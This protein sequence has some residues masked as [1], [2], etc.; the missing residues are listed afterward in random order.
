MV[1]QSRRHAV[2]IRRVNRR[3][4]TEWVLP[5]GHI[6]AGETA[7]LAAEREV[8]EETGITGSAGAAL[9]WIEYEFYAN[10]IK[11]RKIVRHF[12]LYMDG[13]ALST[14]D[15]EVSEVAWFPLER[16]EA[17]LSHG[18]ERRIVRC[19]IEVLNGTRE[20]NHVSLSV[21]NVEDLRG[22]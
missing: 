8:R 12:L 17:K 18:D 15:H 14:E 7:R 3:G 19:A 5:K 10:R 4:R 2:A 20:T 13:G 11:V 9:G 16:L 6:E 22:I 21:D 1:D